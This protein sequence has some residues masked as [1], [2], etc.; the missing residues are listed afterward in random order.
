MTEIDD[1]TLNILVIC[2]KLL[3]FAFSGIMDSVI[4]KVHGQKKNGLIPDD[5][6]TPI[7]SNL[8]I[9]FP[10]GGHYVK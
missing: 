9:I 5:W 4:L 2:N 8:M 3:V 7:P 1:Y 6:C 10:A